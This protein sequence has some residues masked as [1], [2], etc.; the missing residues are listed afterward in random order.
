MSHLPSNVLK[1]L[2]EN[3]PLAVLLYEFEP[4]NTSNFK[5]RYANDAAYE[6]LGQELDSHIGMDIKEIDH[7]LYR[8][9]NL[10][11]NALIATQ[12]KDTKL[13]LGTHLIPYSSHL[14]KPGELTCIPL[15][16]NYLALTINSSFKTSSNQE[17][18]HL[19]GDRKELEEVLFL[20]KKILDTSP[21]I[22]YLY[23]VINHKDL[24]INRSSYTELGYTEHEVLQMGDRVLDEIIHPDDIKAFKKHYFYLLPSLATDQVIQIEYRMR[25]KNTGKYIWFSCVESAFERDQDGVVTKIIGIARNVDGLKR[26]SLQLEEANQQLRKALHFQE[27]IMLTSP[28]IIYVYDLNKRENVFANKSLPEELGYTAEEF[29]AMGD[30]AFILT[31]HPDDLE[32]VFH[33]HTQVLPN[34][35][36][37]EIASIS[38]RMLQ[39][40]NNQYIWLNSTESIFEQ[41]EEGKALTII[42]IARNIHSTKE[43]EADLQELNKELEQLIY[44]VSHD[45]RAPVR[46]IGSYTEIIKENEGTKLSEKGNQ[47]LQRVIQ[48]S[49]RLGDMIDELLEYAKTRNATPK[50]SAVDFKSM[51][52]EILSEFKKTNPQQQIS[53]TIGDLPPSMADKKMM[54]QV[55]E[56]LIGNAI[57]YSS[58]K[59]HTHIEIKAEDLPDK[60]V[61]AIKDNGEGFDQK[62]ENK[63]FAVFQRLHKQ[64][65]FPGNGIGLANVARI[66]YLHDGEIRGKGIVG[67]GA[68]FFLSLPK[69]QVHE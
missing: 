54:I 25:E 14:L 2:I 19:Q 23:D 6:L 69:S 1:Q 37:G 55:W 20:Q 64:S 35:K 38:Y 61:Y 24:F 59:D 42:G 18:N 36:A 40:Q 56:N 39:K 3:I 33:H 53:W 62:F 8:K 48:S 60:V 52:S 28:E 67:K 44:S 16:G 58:K 32:S 66:I 9:G 21:D 27:K 34:L 47:Y 7:P 5:F 41:D 11:V 31:I 22:V 4:E 10:I 12:Q 63:L 46:H 51:V 29:K 65:E 57:K 26:S 43:K 13:G 45:L 49:E 17:Y 15:I 30:Q 68:T 50:K